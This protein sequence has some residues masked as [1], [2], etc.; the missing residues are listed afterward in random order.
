MHYRSV[1]SITT[2]WDNASAWES[3]NVGSDMNC[4]N[5]DGLLDDSS[6][7]GSVLTR[8]PWNEPLDDLVGGAR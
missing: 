4:T 6:H 1:R 2:R 5:G 8:P 3:A 7:S